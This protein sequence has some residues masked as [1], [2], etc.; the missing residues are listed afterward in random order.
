M[1]AKSS[2]AKTK[3][4]YWRIV[5]KQKKQFLESRNL[6]SSLPQEWRSALLEL[7]DQVSESCW[8]HSVRNLVYSWNQISDHKWRS[9]ALWFDYLQN[10]KS[11][12][13]TT[14][15]MPTNLSSFKVAIPALHPS[16]FEVKSLMH[17]VKQ[18][19][20]NP[21]EHLIAA[22]IR[23]FVQSMQLNYLGNTNDVRVLAESED[24]NN[25]LKRLTSEVLEFCSIVRLAFCHYYEGTEVARQLRDDSEELHDLLIDSIL[26]PQVHQI[27]IHAHSVANAAEQEKCRKQQLQFNYLTCS[28][29]GIEPQFQLDVL[30]NRS[31]A[32]VG[33]VEKLR[34]IVGISSPHSKLQCL[35]DTTREI[36]NCIDEYWEDREVSR[37][38]LEITSDQILSLFIYLTLKSRLSDLSSHVWYV[39]TFTRKTLQLSSI[40]YYLTTLEAALLQVLELKESNLQEL[41]HTS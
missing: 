25:Q 8:V 2:R 21:K 24:P 26:Q 10:S 39:Q 34:E 29:V 40:G 36:L 16:S 22:M 27:L 14:M 7:L 15:M 17:F 3:Q 13:K 11:S 6:Q 38:H 12:R 4:E 28:D 1:G 37:E 5:N 23:A 20:E 19:L 33:A 9:N 35:K 18:H 41:Q 30:L 31:T 32:Y